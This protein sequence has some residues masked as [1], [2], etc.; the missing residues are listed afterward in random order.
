LATFEKD[1]L[2]THLRTIGADDTAAASMA[3][4]GINDKAAPPELAW[5]KVA[6]TKMMSES[7]L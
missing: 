3:H 4:T 2:R 7:V 5:L 6:E 1:D